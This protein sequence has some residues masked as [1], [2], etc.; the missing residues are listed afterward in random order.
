[1]S[2]TSLTFCGSPESTVPA[3][4]RVAEMSWLT[5]RTATWALPSFR[6]RLEDIGLTDADEALVDLLAARLTLG[7]SVVEVAIGIGVEKT[8]QDLAVAFGEGRH[9]HLISLARAA[10]EG[11]GVK[12]RVYLDDV[13]QAAAHIL[14]EAGIVLD[15]GLRIGRD[16]GLGYGGRCRLLAARNG[17]DVVVGCRRRRGGCALLAPLGAVALKPRLLVARAPAE[18]APQLQDHDHRNDEQDEGQK[19][20]LLHWRCLP[21]HQRRDWIRKLYMIARNARPNPAAKVRSKLDR[22]ANGSD[23]PA[24]ILNDDSSLQSKAQTRQSQ[25]HCTAAAGIRSDLKRGRTRRG[26]P[27]CPTCA[28]LLCSSSSPFR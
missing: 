20:D 16:G 23:P 10:D 5:K 7:D 27:C 24:R 22:W 12:A 8:L 17:D 1:M 15:A 28:G 13:E 9:D 18:H 6:P 4:S 25:P 14:F 19:V 2:V 26:R 11:I 21:G 3:L